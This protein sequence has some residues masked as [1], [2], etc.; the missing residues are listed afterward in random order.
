MEQL[1]SF[2]FFVCGAD[3]QR[4][5]QIHQLLFLYIYDRAAQAVFVVLN[6]T[7]YCDNHIFVGLIIKAGSSILNVAYDFYLILKT[8]IVDVVKFQY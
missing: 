4:I 2:K 1:N 7:F 6:Q 8:C 3:K 5:N